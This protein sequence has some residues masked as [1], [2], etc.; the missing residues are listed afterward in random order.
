MCAQRTQSI[1]PQHTHQSSYTPT[2]TLSVHS[3]PLA[4]E[5][6]ADPEAL[7]T[8]QQQT[9]VANQQEFS[10]L[11]ARDQHG[12]SGALRVGEKSLQPSREPP[13]SMNAIDVSE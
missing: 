9:I 7:L 1:Y 3:I 4:A 13:S 10:H 2:A 11:A 12:A 5:I 6:I 8:R